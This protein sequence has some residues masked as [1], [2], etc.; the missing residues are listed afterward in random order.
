MADS[1]AIRAGAAYYELYAKDGLTPALARAKATVAA[2]GRFMSS[3]PIVGGPFD[4]IAK[5]LAPV[6]AAV[7]KVGG[8][9]RTELFRAAGTAKQL[10]SAFGAL[11]KSIGGAGA[12]LGAPLLALFKGG[13]DR[14]AGLVSLN[15]QLGVPIELLNK[16]QYA[17]DRA[18]V[19]LDE[20]MGDT[21]GRYT[22]LIRQAPA[23]EP[24]DAR[25][26][27][28]AQKELADATRALQD[29]LL[30]LVQIVTPV[31]KQFGAWV[32]QNAALVAVAVP[33][34]AALVAVGTAAAAVAVALS[35]VITV[36]GV[37]LQVLGTAAAVVTNPYL[38]AAAAVGGLVYALARYTETGRAATAQIKAGLAP[39]L[40]TLKGV[41]HQAR[42]A[43]GAIANALQKGD[44]EGAWEVAATGLEALWAGTLAKL[45]K[46]WHDFVRPIRDA[47]EDVFGGLDQ[48]AAVAW[49]ELSALFG[50]VKAAV[51]PVADTIQKLWRDIRAGA[52]RVAADLAAAWEKIKGPLLRAIEPLKPIL[53]GIAAPFIGAVAL[54]QAAWDGLHKNIGI[55][56]ARLA[57]NIAEVWARV[58]A[59][60]EQILSRLAEVILA[61]IETTVG[62]FGNLNI[63][64]AVAPALKKLAEIREDLAKPIDIEARVKAAGQKYA[65]L[66]AD[67][68]R[69]QA[70]AKKAR[71]AGD[72]AAAKE[73]EDKAAAAQQRLTAAIDRANVPRAVGPDV[74]KSPLRPNLVPE[75][76]IKGQ[77]GG[78]NLAQ[79]LGIADRAQQQTELWKQI[80]GATQKNN[81]DAIGAAV[82]KGFVT[83]FS[84]R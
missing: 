25:T 82:T 46:A 8:A 41:A 5:Q 67:L 71:D 53:I 23:I 29:A 72:E 31:V 34:A 33:V 69:T 83:A 2:F 74:N 51:R 55:T 37:A 57:R 64:F 73:A 65:D 78:G 13:F 10:G 43:V 52:E 56:L 19:S 50:K 1:G 75:M 14:A 35:A 20:V 21:Q 47:W 38:L 39:A 79:T 81:P 77:F 11:G 59:N 12:V 22:D 58:A 80:L 18:G 40:E 9:I 7:A 45:T 30:P 84:V 44:L 36:G 60:V 42:A 28:D 68:Q 49:A 70:A 16:L 54:I 32:K 26:A 15:R 4:A 17:A 24:A 76:S 3:L 66:E 27:A 62:G 6:G 63:G 48:V 61:K